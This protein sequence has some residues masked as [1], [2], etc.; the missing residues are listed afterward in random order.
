MRGRPRLHA[1]DFEINRIMGEIVEL[2]AE[3][4]GA[5]APA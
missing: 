1:Q 5:P 2:V 4:A 3:R